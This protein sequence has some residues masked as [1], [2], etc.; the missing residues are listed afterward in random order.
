[1]KK[2]LYIG[3]L[4]FA[5]LWIYGK[6][7]QTST[8]EAVQKS[9]PVKYANTLHSSVEKARAAQQKANLKIQQN[10]QAVQDLMKAAEAQ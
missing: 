1:M 9:I 3:V 8:P 7:K 6:L 4:A 10:T 5:G 2:I